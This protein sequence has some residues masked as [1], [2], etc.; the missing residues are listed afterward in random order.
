[1]SG[2]AEPVEYVVQVGDSYERR[3]H[4]RRFDPLLQ[5]LNEQAVTPMQSH[6][7]SGPGSPNKAG[8]RPPLNQV[9]VDMVDTIHEGAIDAWVLLET[10][11]PHGSLPRLLADIYCSVAANC[12]L[13]PDECGEV[14][15]MAQHWVRSA[16][17]LLGYE[18]RRVVLADTVCGTCDGTLVVA[19]DASTSVRCIGTLATPSCG[20]VYGR[21]QWLTL[22][23]QSQ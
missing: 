1:M 4:M 20:T 21:T 5:Q 2:F 8:S 18:S 10:H 9:Y 7:N 15:R 13:H 17:V 6:G 22:A 14:A 23:Q 19:A 3:R 11:E 16:R 12:D